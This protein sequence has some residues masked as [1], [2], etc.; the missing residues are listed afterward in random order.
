MFATSRPFDSSSGLTKEENEALME[1]CCSLSLFTSEIMVLR[2][3][4]DEEKEL[5]EQSFREVL[6]PCRVSGKSGKMTVEEFLV[7]SKMLDPQRTNLCRGTE[8]HI[9]I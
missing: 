2:A 8:C 7:I 1:N 3:G 6:T 9:A 4:N 5:P